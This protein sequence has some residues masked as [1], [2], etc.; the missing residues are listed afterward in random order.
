LNT[1][2]N[3]AVLYPR[4][5]T[6]VIIP[7]DLNGSKSASVFEVAHRN[8]SATVYWHMDEHYIGMTKAGIHQ[9][10]FNVSTGKHKLTIVDDG[11]ETV[12]V[13]FEVLEN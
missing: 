10:A 3:L 13:E 8:P 11:G 9:K 2:D 12:A 4:Q 5:N 1:A 7:R 6:K